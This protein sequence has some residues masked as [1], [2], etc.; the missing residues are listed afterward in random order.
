[1]DDRRKFERSRVQCP[2]QI[3]AIAANDHMIRNSFCNNISAVGM[4]ITSFDFY[5]VDGKVH[6]SLLSNALTNMV[7][8]IGRV[9][10]IRELAHQK[11]FK[12]GIEFEDASEGL[13]NKIKSLIEKSSER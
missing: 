10:W 12:I 1:M 11:R 6:F 4:S 3:K 2:L 5:P 9:V 8:A 7:E 13:M